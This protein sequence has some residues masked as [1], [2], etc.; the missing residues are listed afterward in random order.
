M[1]SFLSLERAPVVLV[2]PIIGITPLITLVLAAMFLREREKL[3]LKVVLGSL[4][5]VAGVTLVVLAK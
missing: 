5:V 2:S 1:L 4:V 3:T